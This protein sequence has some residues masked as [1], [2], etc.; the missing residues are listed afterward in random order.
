MELR[1]GEIRKRVEIV[2]DELINNPGSNWQGQYGID[3][4]PVLGK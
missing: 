4:Y 2:M 3:Q 1:P